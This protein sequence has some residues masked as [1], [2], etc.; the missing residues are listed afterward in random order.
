[1]FRWIENERK[2]NNKKI[3]FYYLI[4]YRCKRKKKF[5]IN[6]QFY[7]SIINSLHVTD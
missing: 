1:M 7:P 5:I 2:E 4:R 6:L 3:V